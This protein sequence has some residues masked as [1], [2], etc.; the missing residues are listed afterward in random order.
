MTVIPANAGIQDSTT[1]GA[2]RTEG[3]EFRCQAAALGCGGPGAERHSG[4]EPVPVTVIPAEA[5]V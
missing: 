3:S 4:A 5:G 1:E 2:E